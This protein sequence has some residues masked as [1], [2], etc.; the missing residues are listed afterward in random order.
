MALI[1]PKKQLE[2]KKIKLEITNETFLEIEKYCSWAGVDLNH[3]LEEAAK[4]VLLKD[5]DWK[6]HQSSAAN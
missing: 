4:L 2:T 3:F 1:T 5:K 6:S